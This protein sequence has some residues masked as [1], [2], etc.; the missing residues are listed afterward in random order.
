[1]LTFRKPRIEEHFSRLIQSNRRVNY[2]TLSIP[3]R[4][5]AEIL[6]L[7]TGPIPVMAERRISKDFKNI[8][9]R[10]LPYKGFLKPNFEHCA[11]DASWDAYKIGL[12]V[13]LGDY[14]W[15]LGLY[16]PRVSIGFYMLRFQP[17]MTVEQIHKQYTFK[18]RK[19]QEHNLKYLSTKAKGQNNK[20]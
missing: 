8:F 1:M 3:L 10:L 4:M 2:Y 7:E 17:A 9:I 15:K 14:G 18:R 12:P 19:L 5:M 13:A 20:P 6:P 16:R 11:F